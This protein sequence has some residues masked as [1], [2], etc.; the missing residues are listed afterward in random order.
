MA[1][2]VK[3]LTRRGHTVTVAKS[4]REALAA[5]ERDTFGVVLMDVQMPEMGGLEATRAIRAAEA[6]ATRR[7]PII[8]LTAHAMQGDRERCLAAGMNEYLPK[9]I[10]V[11][12][13]ILAVERLGDAPAAETVPPAERT[14]PLVV[15]DGRQA[16]AHTGGDRRLLKQIIRLFRADCPVTLR[17]IDRAVEARDAE[18]LRMAAHTLKGSIATVGGL[19]ARQQAAA[20]E[21]MGRSGELSGARR[22]CIR[23][24]DEIGRL[25]QALVVAGLTAAPAASTP[26]RTTPA[27]KAAA[28]TRQPAS[29][30]RAKPRRRS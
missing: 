18:A 13:L 27:R 8:A 11:D 15:F 7:L 25:E 17:Q 29:R 10:D 1:L 19:A 16:L 5:M 30:R 14:G 6:G 12:Q 24:R 28:R 4:G 22:A 20:I 3:L 23:L 26:S 21:E 2:A 9:P